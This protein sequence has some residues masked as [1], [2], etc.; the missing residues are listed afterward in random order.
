[1]TNDRVQSIVRDLVSLDPSFQHQEGRLRALIKTIL[2]AAPAVA[3]DQAFADRLKKQLLAEKMTQ[4]RF[5]WSKGTFP[6]LALAGAALA[7]LLVLP[8]Y[9]LQKDTSIQV[10]EF[11]NTRFVSLEGD[12]V[13][14]SEGEA[15]QAADADMALSAGAR[16]QTGEGARAEIALSDGSVVRLNEKTTIFFD[17][18]EDNRVYIVN[19]GGDIYARVAKKSDER[20]FEIATRDH[21]YRALGTAFRVVNAEEAQTLIVYESAVEAVDAAGTEQAATVLEG[22]MFAALDGRVTEIA[23][24]Y[25]ADDFITWNAD[26]DARNP[27]FE[28]YL[29]ILEQVLS[30]SE[31]VHEEIPIEIEPE[32]TGSVSEPSIEDEPQDV[33]DDDDR[34]QK[35]TKILL[36]NAREN[37]IA[38]SVWSEEQIDI[39]SMRVAWSKEGPPSFYGSRDSRT[40][41]I[42]VSREYEATLSAFDGPG[43]YIVHIC[44]IKKGTC[45]VYSNQIQM[46]LQ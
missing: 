26:Q 27:A 36:L 15:W 43:T 22:E 29:G 20:R 6:R 19:E 3:I 16:V 42:D 14:M 2:N 31:D 32:N 30:E 28:N 41:T 5:W 9:F 39:D 17:I 33:G 35:E 45:S 21:T 10:A 44:G 11:S 1:M 8:V 40:R 38:W 46:R 7:L 23:P 12:V 18:L 37:T 25:L 13:W 4:K 24:A 34:E